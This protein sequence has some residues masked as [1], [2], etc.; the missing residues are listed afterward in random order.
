MNSHARLFFRN[1]NADV[2]P[3][4]SLVDDESCPFQEAGSQ[5]RKSQIILDEEDAS[6]Y[7]RS[8]DELA[9]GTITIKRWPSVLMPAPSLRTSHLTTFLAL[10][11]LGLHSLEFHDNL[12]A[13]FRL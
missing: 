7:H 6:Q 4:R 8:V 2:E 12:L 3:I 5:Y 10:L 1:S 9:V 13:L 11:P